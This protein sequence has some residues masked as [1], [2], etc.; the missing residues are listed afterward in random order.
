MRVNYLD[1]PVDVRRE[2]RPYIEALAEDV[3]LPSE[4]EHAWDRIEEVCK[5]YQL[6]LIDRIPPGELPHP[7]IRGILKFYRL[8]VIPDNLREFKEYRAKLPIK[9]VV[10]TIIQKTRHRK[11]HQKKR[12]TRDERYT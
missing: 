3:L 12:T 7:Y 4:E 8:D 10:D 9:S 11:L 6:R 1:L 5:A 2:I